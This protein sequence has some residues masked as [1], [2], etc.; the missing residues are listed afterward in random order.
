MEAHF[1]FMD[2]K[3]ILLKGPYYPKNSMNSMK[4]PS[5]FQCIFHRNRKKKPTMFMKP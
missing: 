4:F 3:L 5:K 2:R 1:V